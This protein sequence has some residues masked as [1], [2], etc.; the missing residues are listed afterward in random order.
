MP[1]NTKQHIKKTLMTGL[2]WLTLSL[3]H[4]QSIDLE[5]T[6]KNNDIPHL[7]MLWQ[8]AFTD[9]AQDMFTNLGQTKMQQ[10][11]G[12]DDISDFLDEIDDISSP[13]YNFIKAE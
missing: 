5:T 9:Y 3:I 11:F 4:G 13:I 7:K 2:L 10:L 1:L 12:V 6:L 8:K